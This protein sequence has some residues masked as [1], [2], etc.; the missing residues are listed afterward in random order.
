MPTG[1]ELILCVEDDATVRGLVA[2]L[3]ERQGY[4]VLTA[5]DGE[6]ALRTAAPVLP[7]VALLITDVV[8]PRMNGRRVARRLRELKPDLKC[9]YMSGYAG[10][11]IAPSDELEP[12]DVLVEKPI[13]PETLLRRVRNVLDGQAAETA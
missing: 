5:A 10:G 1:R 12:G 8:M 11:T 2:L 7:R 9:I 13:D 6:E 3:L 4:Q